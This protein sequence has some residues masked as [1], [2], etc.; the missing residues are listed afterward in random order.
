MG[1]AKSVR[2]TSFPEEADPFNAKQALQE[3]DECGVGYFARD[4]AEALSLLADVFDPPKGT[5][6]QVEFVPRGRRRPKPIE[7]A[8]RDQASDWEGTLDQVKA[9]IE[10]ESL[11]LIGW[12]LRD[13]ADV[14]RRAGDALDPPSGSRG[15]RLKFVGTGPG[16]RADPNKI[17]RDSAIR[18]EL[19]SAMPKA[20]GK[21]EAAID[22][23]KAKGISRARIFRAKKA[24]NRPESQKKR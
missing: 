16:R 13:A 15:R 1:K 8:R 5:A 4:H 2:A 11:T 18:M 9:A 23:L 20:R 12:Y 7:A 24:D 22:D 3:G 17:L 21:Q 19:R 14:Y 10:T 6:R